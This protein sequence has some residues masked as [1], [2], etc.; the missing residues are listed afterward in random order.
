MSDVVGRL[1]REFAITLGVTIVISALV[2]LTLTPMMCARLL[3]HTPETRQGRMYR[4]TQRM[5]DRAVAGYGSTLRWV[6]DH[7]G[8]TLVVAVGTLAA[9]VLLYVVV[10]K[11]FFP[12]QDTGVILGI[13]E[14]PQSIS[15][16][17][18]AERQQALARVILRDPAVASLSSFIGVDGT[19]TTLNSG[20]IQ[21][22]LQPLGDRRT[23]ASDV[24][25][26][27]QPALGAVDGITLYMQ[28]VQDLTVDAR[29][30]HAVPV[31]AR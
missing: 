30:P 14:A 10:P 17:A 13:S 2:S 12:V 6:L 18:M 22:N 11:G 28:P 21:I 7:Q 26:R 27:L 29:E 15:F 8:A 1:F 23:S 19:N 25:R 3:R 9:T 20:R 31:H 5:W 4:V 16:A 24:I